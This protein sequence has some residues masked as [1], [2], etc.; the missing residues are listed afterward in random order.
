MAVDSAG[1]QMRVSRRLELEAL[2]ERIAPAGNVIAEVVRDANGDVRGEIFTSDRFRDAVRVWPS[3]GSHQTPLETAST[4]TR[5]LPERSWFLL[6]EAMTKFIAQG[7][8]RFID[9][10]MADAFVAGRSPENFAKAVLNS[11]AA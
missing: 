11:V 5:V 7:P 9:K 3:F 8:D 6:A 4:G 10:E 1:R 2:E